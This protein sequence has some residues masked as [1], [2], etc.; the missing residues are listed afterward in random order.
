MQA[1]VL[2]LDMLSTSR[3]PVVVILPAVYSTPRSAPLFALNVILHPVHGTREVS[4]T[5][6]PSALACNLSKL[7]PA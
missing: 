5:L 7:R 6:L 1:E 4:S 3:E 2:N